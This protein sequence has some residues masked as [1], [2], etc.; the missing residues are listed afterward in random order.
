MSYTFW[1][2]GK[3]VVEEKIGQSMKKQ[4]KYQNQVMT[5]QKCENHLAYSKITLAI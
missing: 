4:H 1:D 3:K 2:V 5:Y